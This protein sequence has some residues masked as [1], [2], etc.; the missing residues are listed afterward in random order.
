[1]SKIISTSGSHP[2]LVKGSAPGS[3]ASG[4]G[5][6]AAVFA[7]LFGDMQLAEAEAE[8]GGHPPEAAH[9]QGELMIDPHLAQ[10]L[11]GLV[12]KGRGFQDQ[13]GTAE[14]NAIAESD[15]EFLSGLPQTSLEQASDEE[16]DAA[17]RL[18]LNPEQKRTAE[19]GLLAANSPLSDAT[20]N[21]GA[22]GLR[23]SQ[24]QMAALAEDMKQAT[25]DT[26]R[27]MTQPLSDQD[28]DFIGPPLPRTLPKS[29][30]PSLNIAQDK[31][32]TPAPASG[33]KA[34]GITVSAEQP[35]L[36]ASLMQRL[37]A[38]P[39]GTEDVL[40][41]ATL[42][43]ERLA[44]PALRSTDKSGRTAQ[45]PSAPAQQ[46]DLQAGLSSGGS[47]SGSGQGSGQ[48]SG[49]GLTS[50]GALNTDLAEQWLD[51]LDMQDEKWTDQLVRRIDREVRQ[52]GRGLDLELN[53]RNLGRLKVSLSVAQDQ[54]N[55]VLRAE[56]GT[57][58]QMISEAESRLAQM[59]EQAGLRLGQF[60]AYAG[61]QNRGFAQQ[62]NGRD[63][64]GNQART[65]GT[66]PET[67]SKTGDTERS[68]GLVNLTA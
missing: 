44:E 28:P 55:V 42:K 14:R 36:R 25:P 65:A 3:E 23:Q 39:E 30:Q 19:A 51:V 18:D 47:Q 4:E 26:T 21:A 59:L 13:T 40:D 1:M 33:S 67:D 53:P 63:Q 9:S 6:I 11:G 56:S 54:T 58:A 62:Q 43:A 64:A 22:A 66:E 10:M 5:G 16:T 8:A 41:A 27:Q 17:L 45:S 32:K 38:E 52:G 37:A 31:V 57:A 68:D 48:Q 2:P 35:A 50:G 7:A 46:A 20:G 61:G 60:E 24:A 15:E 29:A 12:L 49:T 34:D